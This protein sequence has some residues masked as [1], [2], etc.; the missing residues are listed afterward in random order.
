VLEF[1]RKLVAPGKEPA[2]KISQDTY[3]KHVRAFDAEEIIFR[4]GD[5]GLEMYVI[6]EGRVEI[7]KKTSLTLTK[8]LS[9]F[10]KGDIFGEMALMEKKPRSATAVSVLPT[11]LLVINESLLDSMIEKNP[12]FARKMIRIFS[13]RLRQA[14]ALIQSLMV[15]SRHNQ[16]LAGIRQYARESGNATFKGAQVTRVNVERFYKPGPG[17]T[18]AFRRSDVE[19][20]LPALLKTGALKPSSVGKEEVLVPTSAEHRVRGRP[21]LQRLQQVRQPPVQGVH[22]LQCLRAERLL[23]VGQQPRG[24]PG[25]RSGPTRSGS[26]RPASSCPARWRRGSGSP[27]ACSC[28]C[29]CRCAAGCPATRSTSSSI[30]FGVK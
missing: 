3:D 13:E 16:V 17:A 7:R 29:G 21:R 5:P 12:D 30:S 15:N 23:L 26:C 19:E 28:A 25:S 18:W 2:V 22:L 8:T 14:N 6:V 20:I 11:R 4:E 24:W 9:V 1:L 27:V 10:H